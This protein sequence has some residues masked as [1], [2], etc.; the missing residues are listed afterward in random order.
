MTPYIEAKKAAFRSGLRE[1]V[2]DWMNP[3]AEAY[4]EEFLDT[5]LDEI[6]SRVVLEGTWQDTY[7]NKWKGCCGEEEIGWEDY[8]EKV[9]AAFQ[10]LRTGVE[11]N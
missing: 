4:A 1:R 5:L 10:H 9:E 8:R 2:A 6:E 11:T 7:P 3:A